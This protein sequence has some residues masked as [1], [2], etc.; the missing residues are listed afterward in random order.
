MQK[1]W[2]VEFRTNKFKMDSAQSAKII[3]WKPTRGMEIF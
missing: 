3:Y 2:K 1:T